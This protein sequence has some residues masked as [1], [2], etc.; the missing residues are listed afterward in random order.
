[1]F[2]TILRRFISVCLISITLFFAT[3][4]DLNLTHSAIAKSITKDV[5]NLNPVEEVTDSEYETA[6]INRQREQAMRSKQAKA[7]AETEKASE[8]IGEILN[9]DEIT[10]TLTDDSPATK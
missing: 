10:E 6:K 2:L 7:E 5:N 4:F 3:A 1:M 8:S 9:L